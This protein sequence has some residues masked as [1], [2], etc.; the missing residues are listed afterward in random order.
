MFMFIYFYFYFFVINEYNNNCN[1]VTES[2]QI[3]KNGHIKEE[4][5]W[6]LKDLYLPISFTT[7]W[8]K[9]ENKRGKQRLKY[10]SDIPIQ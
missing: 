6:Q 2:F 4:W 5:T 1:T 7:S 3:S 10:N 8:I 9:E